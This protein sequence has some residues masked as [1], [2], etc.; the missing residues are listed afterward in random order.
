M[1]SSYWG[2]GAHNAL[3]LVGDFLQHSEKAGVIEAK[4]TFAAPHLKAP[5][6]TLQEK[7]GDW[8]ASVFNTAPSTGSETAAVA[9]PDVQVQQP[10]LEPAPESITIPPPAPLPY[11]AP[12]PAP[13]VTP[14]APVI[15]SEPQRVP[16][17][18]R[19]LESARP[20]DTIPGTHVYEAPETAS[21][22]PDFAGPAGDRRDRTR[23]ARSSGADVYTPVP[24][25]T[26]MGATAGGRGDAAGSRTASGNARSGTRRGQ[27]DGAARSDGVDTYGMDDAGRGDT[28]RAD[29][30]NRPRGRDSYGNGQGDTYR[31]DSG[32]GA[33]R[34]GSSGSS[35]G[36]SYGRSDTYGSRN[37]TYGSRGDTYG[38][39]GDTY[40]TGR[41]DAARSSSSSSSSSSSTRRADGTATGRA[42]GTRPRSADVGTFSDADTGVSSVP[43]A[44]RHRD[45]APAAGTLGGSP[46]IEIAPA[47]GGD[48]E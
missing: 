27:A 22:E 41:A 4:A 7:M 2:Q 12:A 39:R 1:R 6:P 46:V 31:S 44:P 42:E 28:V 23:S 9:G 35:R 37:D 3:L 5:E 47:S 43:A 8:W 40:D 18:P 14:E 30:S 16:A 26:E 36:D 48:D 32:P 33:N 38:S 10:Q 21:R 17:F 29:R 20:A 13:A 24:L 19:P 15:A 34:S 11:P 45:A 25:T